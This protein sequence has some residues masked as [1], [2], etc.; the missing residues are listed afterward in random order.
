MSA[1]TAVKMCSRCLTDKP[2]DRF[3][4]DQRGPLGR[5]SECKDCASAF[6][7]G[8]RGRLEQVTSHGLSTYNNWGCRCG[9]C[10]AANTEYQRDYRA[11]GVSA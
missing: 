11:A 9:I 4:P 7:H 2:L 6:R 5:R 10:R 1:E 3:Y 8:R